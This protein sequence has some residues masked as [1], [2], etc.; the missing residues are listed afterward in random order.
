MS[1]DWNALCPV[2]V[3]RRMEATHASVCVLVNSPALRRCTDVAN[4]TLLMGRDDAPVFQR[5]PLILALPGI[6]R[7]GV[8]TL[9]VSIA[10]CI[11]LPVGG[12]RRF[13]DAQQQIRMR[14]RSPRNPLRIATLECR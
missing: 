11:T 12:T 5:I 9:V 6:T 8:A 14:L 3:K 4:E 13:A 7:E 2:R 10:G 1:L